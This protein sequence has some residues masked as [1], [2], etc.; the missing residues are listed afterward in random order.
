MLTCEK[1]DWK[2]SIQFSLWPKEKVSAILANCE[3][4]SEVAN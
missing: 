2:Y 3:I 4:T 1:A